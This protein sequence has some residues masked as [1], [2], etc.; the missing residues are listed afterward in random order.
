M[1]RIKVIEH[2][3][4][5]DRIQDAVEKGDIPVKN[6]IFSPEKLCPKCGAPMVRRLPSGSGK[7]TRDDWKCSAFPTC[8]QTMKV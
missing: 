7:T 2:H 8:R 3:A 5:L 4:L 6:A 1:H